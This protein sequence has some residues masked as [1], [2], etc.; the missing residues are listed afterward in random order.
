MRLSLAT[1]AVVA[2]LIGFAVTLPLIFQAG[3]AIGASDVQ[4][5]M[6]VT[7]SCFAVAIESA[8][9]SWRYKIPV[10][11]AFSTAGLALIGSKEQIA[12][13]RAKIVA[14]AESGGDVRDSLLAGFTA[15]M[16]NL[17]KITADERGNR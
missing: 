11:C 17:R 7:V 6:F 16:Q 4:T 10:V 5:A 9:L 3:K 13:P 2:A 1:N 8:Y 12:N 15:T 14:F